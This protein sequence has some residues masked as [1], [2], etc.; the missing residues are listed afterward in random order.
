[1]INAQ[2]ILIGNPTRKSPLGKRRRKWV[3]NF[4]IKSEINNSMKCTDFNYTRIGTRD[5]LWGKGTQF[6]TTVIN[7]HLELVCVTIC[8]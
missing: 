3:D 7:G 2:N 8:F 1:M 4:N 5:S 6:S